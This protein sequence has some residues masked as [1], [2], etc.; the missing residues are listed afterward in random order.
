M[1]RVQDIMSRPVLCCRTDDTSAVAAGLMWDH[2]CGAVLVVDEDGRLCGIVT[3]RDLCMAAYTRGLPLHEI[4][5][6][7][8]MNPD[9][10]T[11]SIDDP[12]ARVEQLIAEHQVRRIPVVDAELHP[13]GV[14]ALNDLA[15]AA[16]RA[17]AARRNKSHEPEST[18]A[19]G[20]TLAA[21]GEPH[22][23]SAEQAS[24]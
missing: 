11:C 1:T 6:R 9:V 17:S 23:R 4:L 22:G 19:V 21:V 15:R 16:A 10:L 3:D 8:V 7:S 14:V 12:L 5:V 18:D 2:D 20:R 13:V 24:A